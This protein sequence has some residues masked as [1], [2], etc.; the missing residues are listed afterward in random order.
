[1]PELKHGFPPG[2]LDIEADKDG[3]LWLGMMLQ[4]GLAKFDPKT[5]KFQCIALPA[6]INSD[7]AQQAMVVPHIT[8]M[9]KSG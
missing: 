6:K 3:N 2:S 4:G 9:G 5:E 7:V 8:L 1:M